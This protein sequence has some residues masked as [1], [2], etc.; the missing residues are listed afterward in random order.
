VSVVIVTWNS[1]QEL[2]DCLRSLYAHPPSVAWQAIV[3]DNGSS[4]GS[5]ER[6]RR[7][8]PAVRIIENRRNRGLA[9]ANNQ[10]ILAS[11]APFVLISNPDVL[12][13]DGSVDALLDLMARR[14]RAAFAVARHLHRDG[15]LQTSAGD[16]PSVADA[17]L[18]H[19]LS[20]RRRRADGTRMWWHDW[21]HDEERAIGHGA[22]ACYL[23]RREALADIGLQDERFVLDWEGFDWSA[24]AWSA[25]WE[26]WFSPAAA[27]THLG[28]VSLRQAPGRWILATHRGMYQYLRGRTHPLLRPALAAIVS[29][30]A[31]VKCAA[32][33]VGVPVYELADRGRAR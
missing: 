24:R 2:L 15:S 22:E 21:P 8:H 7:E 29:L 17:L 10:G 32:V 6:V 19:R 33:G 25:G 27:V 20:H 18:G 11:S 12:Y 9:A 5:L 13:R 16:L 26:V 28:G 1:G 31:L 23:V 14:P 30:R 4:D 3:V